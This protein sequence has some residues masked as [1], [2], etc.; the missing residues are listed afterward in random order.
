MKKLVLI[1]MMLISCGGCWESLAL[2]GGGAAGGM[3][4]ARIIQQQKEA[5]QANIDLMEQQKTDLEVELAAATDEAE[6]KRIQEQLDNTKTVLADLRTQ[7]IALDGLDLGVKTD[8][9]D[10]Q[11]VIPTIAAILMMVLADRERR[12]KNKAK[13]ALVEV[14]EGGEEFKASADMANVKTFKTA[15][16]DKQSSET[17]KMVAV[18]KA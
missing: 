5:N 12:R 15:M 3:T 14:V 10:P 13:T 4:A 1:S 6:K 7:K 18:I 8:W 2:V 9:S 16:S 11:A 17:K